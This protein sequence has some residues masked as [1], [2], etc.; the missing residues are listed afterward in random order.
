MTAH[1]IDKELDGC[2]TLFEHQGY[3]AVLEHHAY[4]TVLEHQGYFDRFGTPR[5]T[6]PFWNTSGP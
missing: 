2:F 6:L 5:R 3:F 1:Y 4:F